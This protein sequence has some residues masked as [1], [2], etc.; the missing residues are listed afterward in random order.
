MKEQVEDIII[1]EK[2]VIIDEVVKAKDLRGKIFVSYAPGRVNLIG[3][4][5]DYNMGFVMPCAIDLKTVALGRFTNHEGEISIE[6]LNLREKIRVNFD[7]I[8]PTKTWADYILGPIFLLKNK[9]GN[10]NG[11][12][13]IIIKGNVPLGGGLS[14]SA[15][16]EVA[17]SSL[18]NEMFNLKMEK[19]EIVRISK[20]AENEFVGVPC[21]IMDQ[22]SSVFGKENHAM[23]IDC[24]T[25]EIEYIKFPQSWSVVICDSGVKHKLGESEYKKRQNECQQALKIIR[26]RIKNNQIE[27]LRDVDEDMLDILKR[28]N[29]IL[30]KRAKFVVEENKRVLTAKEAIK[31]EDKET[32]SKVFI[33]SHIGLQKEYEVS[34]EELDKLVEIA[35]DFKYTIGARMTGAGFGGNTVNIVE[36]GK[37]KEFAEFVQEKYKSKTNKKTEIRIVKISDGA[38]SFQMEI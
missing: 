37:E 22:M 25:E 13:E 32:I 18:L 9:I 5:T 15:S 28:E 38:K 30:W 16:C 35:Y 12:L 24:K 6:S 14:S 8:K 3:E 7:N 10:L 4:H 19:I 11:G 34:C 2:E 17:V 36:K 27:S 26:E 1:E 29:E 33:Q 23:V 31:K 21:G 20:K